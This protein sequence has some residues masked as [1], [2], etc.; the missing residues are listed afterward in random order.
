[1]GHRSATLII[2]VAPHLDTASN[3]S[4]WLQEPPK[5]QK[6]QPSAGI[7]PGVFVLMGIFSDLPKEKSFG[8]PVPFWGFQRNAQFAVTTPRW[9]LGG[10]P[11]PIIA[12]P[13][14]V[15]MMPGCQQAMA[16][17][18]FWVFFFNK[19][20]FFWCF[21]VVKCFL[22]F[23]WCFFWCFEFF[24]FFFLMFFLFWVFVGCFWMFFWCFFFFLSF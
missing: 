24:F 14:L 23:F 4:W 20:F 9:K 8:V 15:P 11:V 2:L 6:M 12:V 19:C 13:F 3:A 5:S 22:T 10:L 7:L 1:M 17:W 16:G 21:E 18:F